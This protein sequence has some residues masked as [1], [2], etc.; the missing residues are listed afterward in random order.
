MGMDKGGHE[1]RPEGYPV[2]LLPFEKL[3]NQHLERFPYTR[4]SRLGV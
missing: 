1:Q 3:A 2:Q 4:E